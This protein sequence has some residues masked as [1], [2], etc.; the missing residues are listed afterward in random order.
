LLIVALIACCPAPP[1]EYEIGGYESLLT[2][3]GEKTS[4]LVH[5]GCLTVAKQVAQ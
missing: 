4:A 3:W 5:D 1:D 2:F